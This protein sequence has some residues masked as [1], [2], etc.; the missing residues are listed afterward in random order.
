MRLVQFECGCI[1]TTPVAGEWTVFME[2][3]DKHKESHHITY[4][5]CFYSTMLSPAVPC[6]WVNHAGILPHKPLDKMREMGLLKELY[7][8]VKIGKYNARAER[9]RIVDPDDTTEPQ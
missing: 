3:C 9:G 7:L 4:R 2:M 5:P 1:S 8:Y 6:D